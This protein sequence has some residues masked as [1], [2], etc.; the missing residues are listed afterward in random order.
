MPL[1]VASDRLVR[2]DKAL[3]EA[4]R[5]GDAVVFVEATSE[6][7]HIPQAEAQIAEKAVTRAGLAFQEMRR[8]TDEQITHFFE[9]FASRV[10]DPRLWS[11]VVE[12]NR[13]DIAR[14]RARGRS[15]T[16]LEA[17]PDMQSAMAEGLR[18]WAKYKTTRGRVLE[19]VDHGDWRAELVGA[20]LGVVAFVFEGR[21]NVV[22]DATGVLRG[23][24]TVVFRIGG[25]ALGTARALMTLVLRPALA[26]AGLP[27][28]AVELVAST[29]HA[30]AWALFRDRRLG[31][32]V[33]RGSGPAVNTLGELAQGAGVPVSLHGTGGAWLVVGPE[34][35]EDRVT[36]NVFDSLDRKVCNTLNVCC[37]PR[38]Q[39]ERLVPAFLAGLGKAA[40]RRNT[41]Y[42]LHVSV[43]SEAFVPKELFERRVN[44]DRSSGKE[45][46]LQ[47]EVMP[48][49]ELGREWEWE[50]SPEVSL[51][52]V[53]SL[54]EAIELFNRHSPKFVACLLSDSPQV[55]DYF[56]QS[57]DAPFVGDGFTR[58]VDGQYALNRPEL[59]LSNWERGRLL[60][61][62]GILAGDSVFS[63]R[64]RVRGTSNGRPV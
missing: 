40:E 27:E 14:A 48:L 5:P 10:L 21:P 26:E 47:A 2:V 29:S 38:T 42:K 34:V 55:H 50:N 61:R 56:S 25:D 19:T 62:G 3:A 4:F 31:L 33:A 53:D 13:E 60:G 28:S 57:V 6:L 32:A 16:R 36:K 64:T 45:L 51:C 46:E 23:G 1:V 24:N 39:A 12:A 15:T 35:V 22:A 43:G 17:T 8:V 44:I 63:V 20:E 18:A 37:L 7:L 52:I 49:E 30:A 58:W 59:G 9:G 41:A 54:D 11:A